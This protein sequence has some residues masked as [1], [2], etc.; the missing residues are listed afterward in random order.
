[1]CQYTLLVCTVGGTPEPLIATL[2]KWEP[3]RILFLPSVE[4]E[5]KI[6]EIVNQ[7]RQELP[8]LD[9]GRYEV[10]QIPDAQNLTACVTLIRNL[11]S[12]VH[13]W[14]ALGPEYR[15][16]VDFTGGTKCMTAA[17]ALVAHRWPCT[18]SYVGGTQRDKGNVGVVVS[19]KEHVLN[20]QNPW[21]VLGYQAVEEAVTLFNNGSFAAAALVLDA[22][23]RSIESLSGKRTLATL[24]AL[25]EL[26]VAWD[27]FDFKGAADK[28]QD[29]LKNANDLCSLFPTT[30]QSL[31]Q[32]LQEHFHRLNTLQEATGPSNELV[33]DLL[34]NACRCARRQRY[35]D[36]VAR[37]YRATEALAQVRLAELKF[38]DTANVPLDA[39]PEA[40]RHKWRDRAVNGTVKL[41]LQ[42]AYVLLAELND[43]L[44]TKF[45]ELGLAD[46]CSP[47]AARND[48]ILAHGFRPISERAYL[49]LKERVL[50]LA[51]I[52]EES[53]L[54]Q[55]PT[56]GPCQ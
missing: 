11:S 56:L 24:K 4:T 53:H 3:C 18:F 37:L 17:L 5:Q 21:D 7:A 52:A 15:V 44:G 22:P 12:E 48:S 27:R 23:I 47:L 31:E 38:P 20:F 28:L 36:A 35:E 10:K 45:R 29:V 40:L 25:A 2:K 13:Q 51:G 9:P 8:D 32:T 34:A 41:A 43:P 16:V 1:M 30:F 19:G 14:V 33:G 50:S 55:F 42:D 54:V 26:Y 6:P 49:S 39:L 46:R